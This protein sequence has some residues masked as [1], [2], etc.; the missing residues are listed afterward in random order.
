M[1]PSHTDVEAASDSNDQGGNSPV[2]S[3][4]RKLSF[5]ALGRERQSSR[6][7]AGK[8]L[9]ALIEQ[10]PEDEANALMVVEIHT[11]QELRAAEL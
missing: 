11:G 2:E 7:T 8:A 3:V 9:D 1:W 6:G 5:R 10:L 4:G